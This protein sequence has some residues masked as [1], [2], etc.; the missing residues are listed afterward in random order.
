MP[1]PRDQMI[2]YNPKLSKLTKNEQAVLEHLIDAAKLI[3]PL[4]EKV[5]FYPDDVSR[6]EI[7]KAAKENPEILSP[8]TVVE[9]NDDQLT[10]IF[11]HEKYKDD[12]REIA[13]LLN[14]AAGIS[15]NPRFAKGLRLQAKALLDGSYDEATIYWMGMK[16][17]IL[18]INIGPVERYDD[19]L[20]FTKAAYQAWVG[21]MDEEK[22]HKAQV[23][24]ELILSARRM[25]LMP[26]EKVDYYDKVQVRVDDILI[27]SGLISRTRFIGVNLPNDV[28][29]MEQYGS[30]ITMFNQTNE[31]RMETEIIPTFNKLFSKEFKQQ[32]TLED[33]ENGSSGFNMLHELAHVYLRYKNSEKNLKDLFPYIDELAAYVMGI[34]V[35]G[36]L[37]LKDI[38]TQHELESIIVAFLTKCFYM[39]N[40][41]SNVKSRVH[42]TVGCGIFINYLIENGAIRQSGGISWPNFTKIFVAIDH[43]S[44]ILERILSSGKREDAAAFI[45]QYQNLQIKEFAQISV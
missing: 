27:F 37:F 31:T 8:Y 19:K 34:K 22:T 18:D 6:D 21:V 14:K 42:Y 24:K 39:V 20:F 11:Y 40:E 7:E 16:P 44:E 45:K 41:E 5:K 30:E 17:Y 12:L 4:Y 35:C 33:L 3:E 15:E 23:Y 26:S 29:L 13:E 9:K 32:F 1:D 2:L 36:S 38:A 10:Y 28:S 43:L 25:A